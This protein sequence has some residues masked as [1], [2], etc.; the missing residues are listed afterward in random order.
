MGPGTVVSQLRESVLSWSDPIAR[1]QRAL[2]RARAALGRRVVAATGLTTAA[3]VLLPYSG[4]GLPDVGWTAAAAAS[5]ASAVL[6]GRRLRRLER[7]VPPP[8][9]PR[10]Q[11]IA[12]PTVERLARAVDALTA[13]LAR[14]GSAGAGAA[15]EA[16]DAER[17]LRDLA[18]RIDAVE[19]ALGVAPAAAGAGLHE[20]RRLL[21]DRLEEGARA[22]ERL[23][24][25]AAECVAAS[26][27]GPGEAFARRRLEEA[28]E[29][30]R[31]LAAGLHEVH[32]V[33]RGVGL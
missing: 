5:V 15:A 16:A 26:A 32:A 28:T 29:G 30:L 10:P 9:R 19:A 13:L 14:L 6:A 27:V 24:A 31:G 4:L 18:A 8:G 11:S 3:V 25:A 17:S 7:E 23:V 22:Y 2:R 20:A 1:H 33:S 21:L 12:R